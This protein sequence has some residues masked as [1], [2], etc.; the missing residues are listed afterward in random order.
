MREPD[1][2]VGRVLLAEMLNS[3]EQSASLAAKR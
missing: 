1:A 2:I 3:Y